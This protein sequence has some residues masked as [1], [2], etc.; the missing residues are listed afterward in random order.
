MNLLNFNDIVVCRPALQKDTPEVMELCSHIWEGGD[1]VPQV[2]QDWLADPE[3]LLGIAEMGGHV[4][5]IFKLTRFQVDE[6]Y[7]EGLRVHPDVQGRGIAAHIHEYV[8]ETWRRMGNSLIRLTTGSYNVKVHQMCERSGFMRVAEFIP[9]RA[10]V[11]MEESENFTRLEP[12]EASRAMEF[13]LPSPAHALSWGLINLGWVFANP[14]LKHVQEAA[15]DGHAWWWRS[16]AGY[17]SIWEDEEDGRREPGIQLIACPMD[18]LEELLLDYRR[19]VGKLGYASAGW[20]APNQPTVLA[21]LERAG[22]QR[23]WDVSL[24]IFELRG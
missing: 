11:L 1:Y 10:P 5:G 12:G 9:Y 13:V 3:G 4:V 6:W 7:M 23:S 15:R 21:C 18:H 24:Y 8:L 14:Q 16:G 17:L 22:F 2:W 19:L 20:V